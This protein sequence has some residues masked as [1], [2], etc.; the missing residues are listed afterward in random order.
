VKRLRSAVVVLGVLAEAC[1]GPAQPHVRPTGLKVPLPEGWAARAAKDDV[2]EVT[3][4]GRVV[5]SFKLEPDAPLPQA[6]ELEAAVVKAGGESLGT[7]PLPD[8]LLVRFRVAFGAEGVLGARRLAGHR[9]LCASEPQA[10]Q[11]ELKTVARL[12]SEAE[13]ES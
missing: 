9:L 2:L 6:Q 5:M 13:W 4:E 3:V 8:G 10:M 11:G 12:C 7:L 1:S